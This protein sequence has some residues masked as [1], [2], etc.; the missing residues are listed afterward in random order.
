MVARSITGWT[1]AALAMACGVGVPLLAAPA[2]IVATRIAGFREVGAAFKNIND[3]LR[4]GSPQ[5]YVIQISARQIRDYARQHYGWF[6]AGSGPKPGVKT[7]AKPEIWTQAAAFKAAQD[8]FAK[9]ANAFATVAGSGDV[10]KMRA[11]AKA[12]GQSCTTCHR[13]FRVEP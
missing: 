13:S 12:L 6:P 7:A 5:T 4:S 9:Q 11:Q 1:A 2:N 10:A 3:E 8:G